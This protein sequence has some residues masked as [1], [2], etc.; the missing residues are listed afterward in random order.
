MPSSPSPYSTSL[1]LTG[2]RQTGATTLSPTGC[3]MATNVRAAPTGSMSD[4]SVESI[5]SI[6]TGLATT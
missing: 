6:L 1:S 3:S 4:V 2:S 5:G